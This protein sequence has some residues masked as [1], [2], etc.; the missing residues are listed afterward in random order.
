MSK[1]KGENGKG[2][3]EN[4]KRKGETTLSDVGVRRRLT[5]KYN[6]FRFFLA[7]MHFLLYLCKQVFTRKIHM[8]KKRKE[9]TCNT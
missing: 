2:K 1:S 4:S 7:N 6:N 9:K 8:V 3:T 5:Q